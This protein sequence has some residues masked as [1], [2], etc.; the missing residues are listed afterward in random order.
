MV[1]KSTLS[2]LPDVDRLMRKAQSLAA[3]DAIMSPDWEY[4]YYSFNP[5]W[6]SDEVMASRKNGSGDELYILFTPFGSIIK[7]FD[8]ESVMSPWAREDQS[9]WPGIFDGVPSVFEQFLKE[10]SFDIPDT[11]FCIW[12]QNGESTWNVSDIQYPDADQNRDGSQEQLSLFVGDP[13]LYVEFAKEYFEKEIPLEV[14]GQ[15][16]DHQ[17]ISQLM[18]RALNPDRDLQSVTEALVEIQYPAT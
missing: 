1:M 8:H 5:N 17:P 12:R 15:I 16:Y 6:D 13:E 3:L 14:V 7:G 11:T 9:I 10:P 18:I 4:R 2:R